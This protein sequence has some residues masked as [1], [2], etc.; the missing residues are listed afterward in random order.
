M[1][2]TNGAI[3]RVRTSRHACNV[4]NAA[5]SP[6]QNRRRDLRTYQLDRSST[7]ADS[8]RPARTESK[9]SS[10]SSTSVT[11]WLSSDNTH[12]SNRGRFAASISAAL[13]LGVQL[14]ALA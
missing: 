9:S 1:N 13:L 14:L 5:G 2:G 7:N 4:V 8:A 10:A 3:N 11:S 6:S 12:L